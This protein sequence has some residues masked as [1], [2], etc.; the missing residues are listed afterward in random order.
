MTK[1]YLVEMPEDSVDGKLYYYKKIGAWESLRPLANAKE[2]VEVG[3]VDNMG[4]KFV[5]VPMN[6]PVKLF[7]V[8]DK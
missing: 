8:E 3:Y 7:A 4:A 5:G 2:A 6:H 1:K